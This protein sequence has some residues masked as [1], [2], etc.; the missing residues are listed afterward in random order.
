MEVNIVKKSTVLGLAKYVCKDGKEVSIA[1]VLNTVATM[2]GW[3]K[4]GLRAGGSSFRST[5]RN[6]FGAMQEV[7]GTL[8]KI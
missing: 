2:Q 3:A 1:L 8:A 7:A 5:D 6:S 4:A